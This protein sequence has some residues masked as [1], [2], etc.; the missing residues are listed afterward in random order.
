MT[1]RTTIFGTLASFVLAGSVSGQAGEEARIGSETNP[2]VQAIS[3]TPADDGYRHVPGGRMVHKSCIHQVEEGE[4]VLD[5]TTVQRADGTLRHVP[6]C[7]YPERR[8]GG[9]PLPTDNGWI[10]Y[11]SWG[12]SSKYLIKMYS[13]W[14]VPN[15]PTVYGGQTIYFF[16][17]FQNK[18]GTALV[19]PVLEYG[20]PAGGAK[21]AAQSWYGSNGTYWNSAR[22]NAYPGQKVSGNMTASSCNSLG[23]CTWKIITTL[24]DTWSTTLTI[25]SYQSFWWVDGAV[26]EAYS[27]DSCSKYTKSGW[28]RFAPMGIQ[29]AGGAWLTPNWSP[30]IDN[31]NCGEQVVI[32][33]PLDIQ[34]G[35]S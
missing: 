25:T 10:E 8:P 7:V 30:W 12:Y 22:L 2:Q 27:V 16:H 3:S 24:D 32:N 13:N 6:A 34:L 23:H 26:L 14:H 18:E 31:Y 15:P 35:I 28:T 29:Q 33:N 21:F 19:Q 11:A 9:F 4:V 1:T 17:A 5:D 20:L